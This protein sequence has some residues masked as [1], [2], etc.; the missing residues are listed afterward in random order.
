MEVKRVFA[1]FSVMASLI[2]GLEGLEVNAG[3]CVS[4]HFQ[5][6]IQLVTVSPQSTCMDTLQRGVQWERGAV[7]GGSIT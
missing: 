1:L 2:L 6:L 7:D 3:A 4:L 5:G